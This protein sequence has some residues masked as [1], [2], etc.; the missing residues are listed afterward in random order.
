MVS[1]SQYRLRTFA[2]IF[3]RVNL[4]LDVL[5]V[6]K[7][8]DVSMYT[9]ME[10]LIQRYLSGD[11]SLKEAQQIQEWLQSN[12]ENRQLFALQKKLWLSNRM[13]AGFDANKIE[14]D[15]KKTELKI[16]YSELQRSLCKAKTKILYE[17]NNS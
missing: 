15:R 12:K 17:N 8:L 11:V 9:E 10:L 13:L 6:N 3:F 7:Q 16:R 1:V 2:K 14:H 4:R 5:K